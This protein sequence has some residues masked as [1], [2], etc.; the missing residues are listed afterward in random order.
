MITLPKTLQEIFDIVAEH[1][2][3][4][5]RRSDKDS[6]CRYRGPDGLKCAAG[7]LISDEE[8]HPDMEERSWST[9]SFAGIAPREFRREIESLQIIHDTH[10]PGN[11]KEELRY[12]AEQNNLK[13]PKVLL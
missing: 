2:M 7:I 11:W 1:L 10:H 4:Q 3:Q 12:F 5:G 9:L 6:T 13:M 8:Y